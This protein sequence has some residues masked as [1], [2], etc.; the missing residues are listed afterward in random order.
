MKLRIQMVGTTPMLMHNGRLADPLD[1][2]AR[3]MK[4]LTAKRRKTDEDYEQLGRV[5]FAG[6]IYIDPD[7]GPYLPADNIW[8]TIYDSAKK[9]N[10]GPRIKEGFLVTSEINP[11]AYPGPRDLDGLWA[12]KR[13]VF[14]KVVRNQQNRVP[15]T[16][17]IFQQWRADCEA[18][19][20]ESVLNFADLQVIAQRAGD[21]IGLGDWRPRFGRFTADVAPA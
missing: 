10:Q 20:D 5:E 15:R 7:V 19:L 1:P 2:A 11:L 8:R 17:P 13:F 3:S 9:S 6:S 16:R 12:D 18:L 21:L 4:P 14:R